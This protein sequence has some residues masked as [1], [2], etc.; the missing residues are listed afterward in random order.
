MTEPLWSR[1]CPIWLLS[2]PLS[3]PARRAALRSYN[4]RDS[5]CATSPGGRALEADIA[6][7]VAEVMAEAR[8]IEL[9]AVRCRP[10]RQP[11]T[12]A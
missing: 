1:A 2:L 6:A 11:A 7:T 5:W 3:A 10:T 4:T 8:D 9:F 12:E